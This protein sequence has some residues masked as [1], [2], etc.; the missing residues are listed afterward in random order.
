MKGGKKLG[1]ERRL[2]KMQG[3]Y[4]RRIVGFETPKECQGCSQDNARPRRSACREV[5]IR[6]TLCMCGADEPNRPTSPA[7]SETNQQPKNKS[8]KGAASLNDEEDGALL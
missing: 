4:A 8:R 2:A 3:T 1:K 5:G 6:C 7:E